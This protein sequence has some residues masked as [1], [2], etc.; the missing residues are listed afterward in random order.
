MFTVSTPEYL[1]VLSKY[2]SEIL[3]KEYGDGFFKEGA[4]TNPENWNNWYIDENGNLVILFGAYQVAAYVNGEP[5]VSIRIE[6]RSIPKLYSLNKK[7]KS[8]LRGFLV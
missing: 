3:S 1:A 5:D 6:N 2:A 8:P 4:D 7:L